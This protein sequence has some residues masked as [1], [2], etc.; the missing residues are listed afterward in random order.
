MQ[1]HGIPML[2]ESFGEIHCDHMS[3]KSEQDVF[4]RCILIHKEH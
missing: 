4:L 3:D 2:A 1:W